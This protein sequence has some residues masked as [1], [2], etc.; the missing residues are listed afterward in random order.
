MATNFQTGYSGLYTGK[1]VDELCEAVL[2]RLNQ[3][4]SNYTRYSKARIISKLDA[5]QREFVADAK[6]L[7]GWAIIPMRANITSYALPKQCLPDGLERARFYDTSTSYT[8]L[9]LRDRE[10][11][12]EHYPGWMT[13]ESGDPQILVVGQWF[14]NVLK[15]DVYP[16]P[17]TAGTT[18][19]TGT[20][21]GV[22]TGGTALPDNWNNIAGTATGGS[23]TTLEDTSVDFTAMGLVEGMAVVKTSGTPGSEP[24]GYIDTIATTQ[25]TFTAVLTNTGSFA[26]GDSYEIM[27]GEVGVMTSLAN[28]EVY[29]FSSDVGVVAQITVPANNIWVEFR[30]YPVTLE[31]DYSAYQKPE[32]PWAW[33]DSLAD[34]AAAEI[35]LEDVMRVSKQEQ[36]LAARL[37]GKYSMAVMH[38]KMK[39]TMP[40]NRP[41]KMS[42]RAKR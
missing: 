22:V 33:H 23:T 34:G 10:Y 1:T 28:E 30:R 2:Y 32:I 6:P 9:E 7:T 16:P 31:V 29:I 19:T 13:A 37:E 14:G 40:F 36:A 15:F 4:A 41:S 21:L 8:D 3:T 17:D 42:V 20:D 11:M 27:S 5:K 24:I 26:A 35:L 38:C 25:L 12:D 39:P 18:Y